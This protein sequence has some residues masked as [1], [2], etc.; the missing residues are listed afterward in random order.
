LDRRVKVE[1]FAEIRREY[2]FGIGTIKSVPSLGRHAGR[3]IDV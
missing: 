3:G 1:L 2:Q